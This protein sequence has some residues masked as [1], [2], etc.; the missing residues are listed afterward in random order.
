[1]TVGELRD[2]ITA[3]MLL[4][5]YFGFASVCIGNRSIAWFALT[6]V[7]CSIGLLTNKEANSKTCSNALL[8]HGIL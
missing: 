7:V 1:M 5:M 6:V 8:G 2:L 4:P 3:F